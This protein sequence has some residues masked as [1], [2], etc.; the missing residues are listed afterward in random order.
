MSVASRVLLANPVLDREVRQRSRS[1]RAVVLLVLFLGLL[2]ATA[3]LVQVGQRASTGQFVDPFAMPQLQVSAGRSLLEW[4][5]A[6]ML[7]VLLFIVPGISANAVSGERE[8]QTLVPL[9]VTLM[10]PVGI[11][12]GKIAAS[13]AFA[14]LLVVAAAPLLALPYLLGGVSLSQVL[15]SLFVLAVSAVVVAAIGVSCS[16]IFRRTQTATLMAYGFVL[17]LVV[18]TPVA[19]AAAAV[20]DAS[21]GV[22]QP[23]PPFSIVYPNPFVGLADAAGNLTGSG[24]GPFSPIKRAMLESRGQAVNVMDT[25]TGPVAIDQFG[26]EVPLD[27]LGG[28]RIPIWVRTLLIQGGLALVLFVV[29]WRR[30]RAPASVDR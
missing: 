10:G 19:L 4:L 1:I 20:V 25:P 18:G 16:A 26:N 6:T 28:G 22:D 30:L 27:D 29:A 13:S 21:R 2:L 11:L 9:Q 5:L 17:L 23:N 7:S 12:V 3:A 24:T 15:V 14:L 8:R